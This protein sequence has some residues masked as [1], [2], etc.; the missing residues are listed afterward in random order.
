MVKLPAGAS[1]LN[2]YRFYPTGSVEHLVAESEKRKKKLTDETT[3]QRAERLGTMS[4]YWK[5]RGDVYNA[6]RNAKRAASR[7]KLIAE[8]PEIVKKVG[9]PKGAVPKV[10]ADISVVQQKKKAASGFEDELL[11]LVDE[12]IAIP[13]ELGPVFNDTSDTPYV[14]VDP[15]ASTWPMFWI[16]SFPKLKP[17]S[18]NSYLANFKLAFNAAGITVPANPE[19]DPV[20]YAEWYANSGIDPY[21]IVKANSEQFGEKKGQQ[22]S[23][24]TVNGRA[25]AVNS[26]IVQGILQ[27]LKDNK[28]DT[29][30]GKK[31]LR[32][33]F[34]FFEF[35]NRAKHQTGKK[36][37]KQAE[38][39][40]DKDN[41]IPW[42]EWM[43]AAKTY[44]DKV[45][46]TSG[47][48]EGELRKQ[49]KTSTD[50]AA[51]RD[52][53]IVAAFSLLPI[54][55]LKPWDNTVIKPAGYEKGGAEAKDYMKINYATP[56]GR[57]FFND[58]KNYS[59]VYALADPPKN[60]PLEQPIKSELF[61][62]IL[63]TWIAAKP[64]TNPY[65]FP[66]SFKANGTSAV[67]LGTRLIA[68]AAAIDPKKR[69]FG[70]RLM[71]RAYIKW[72]R[73]TEGGFDKNDV[74]ALIQFMLSVHQTSP[75]VNMG[76]VK[77]SQT[78]PVNAIKQGKA[79]SQEIFASVLDSIEKEEAAAGEEGAAPKQ[80]AKKAAAK[81]KKAKKD[82]SDSESEMSESVLSESVLSESDLESVEIEK[83]KRIKI[84]KPAA[85]KK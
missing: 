57:V 23:T 30:Q 54:T 62:K 72:V 8:Q 18:Q 28:L 26:I 21:K 50:F 46:Y 15:D 82:E 68:L 32:D 75:L 56:D 44:I 4:K 9:R 64:A 11:L 84:K 51:A 27:R 17:G 85:K 71:R 76:Y 70:N 65:L 58:F 79:S 40:K 80:P 24:S 74:N 5:E 29:P 16:K 22:L 55:R 49:L 47:A 37:N 33:H 43:A 73:N 67:A 77:T 45:F 59:S 63:K 25:S 19:N 35:Q 34:I 7:A 69:K 39:G 41:S 81:K 12:Y 52:A 3:Q 6:N 10:D 20:A 14:A 36:F 83:P 31:L 66:S 53:V 2:K 60:T 42:A 38:T 48:K 1:A 78:T 61:K 13:K